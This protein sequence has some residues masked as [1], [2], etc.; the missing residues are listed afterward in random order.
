MY[1]KDFILKL[2]RC[3]DIASK[4][5]KE[6]QYALNEVTIMRDKIFDIFGD[7]K[8]I[9]KNLDNLYLYFDVE[10]RKSIVQ[11]FL[12]MLDYGSTFA[13]IPAKEFEIPIIQQILSQHKEIGIIHC[14][15]DLY[16]T[17]NDYLEQMKLNYNAHNF[18]KVVESYH[19]LLNIQ[20]EFK[21]KHNIK[22][23]SF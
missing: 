9:R 7:L 17:F 11:A 2:K 23:N 1:F 4:E 22:N 15:E 8:D 14:Y 12:D 20:E 3:Y 13:K 5:Q 6:A 19:E 21:T 16:Y 10:S 18:N